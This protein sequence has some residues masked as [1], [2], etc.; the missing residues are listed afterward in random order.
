[1][2]KSAMVMATVNAPY[3]EQLK[4]SELALCLS[5]LA[6]AKLMPGHVSSFFG[7]IDPVLQLEFARQF[8]ITH[9]D[10]TR[11]AK[12]FASFSGQSYALAR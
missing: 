6:H 12:D 1:M 2:T 11:T 8:N 3:R 9:A 5:D 7:E 4:A 10:L